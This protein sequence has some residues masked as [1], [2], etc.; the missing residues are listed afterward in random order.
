[1]FGTLAKARAEEVQRPQEKKEQAL[2]FCRRQGG[3]RWRTREELEFEH[4]V[5]RSNSADEKLLQEWAD[6]LRAEAQRAERI[7][8]AWEKSRWRRRTPPPSAA[9]RG[10]T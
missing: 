9:D 7:S 10:R 1:M 8:E 5:M 6:E 3:L 2:E 4:M